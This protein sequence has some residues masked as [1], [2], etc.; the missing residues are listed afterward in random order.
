MRKKTI[1]ALTGIGTGLVGS[2]AGTVLTK[3]L[4]DS[5]KEKIEKGEINNEEE[6]KK[7]RLKTRLSAV[8]TTLLAGLAIA[9]GAGLAISYS[10][11]EKSNDSNEEYGK[12]FI[13]PNDKTN[14]IAEEDSKWLYEM[15]DEYDNLLNENKKNEEIS[16]REFGIKTDENQMDKVK[17][18]LYDTEQSIEEIY[19]D[20]NSIDGIYN[21]LDNIQKNND[22]AQ[23]IIEQI[24]E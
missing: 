24:N 18:I 11:D 12:Y 21:E 6:I 16:T 23:E 4:Y 20:L 14:D 2:I 3:K 13:N 15:E 5:N 22:T 7:A 10:K 17:D 8:G 9:S 19:N 1:L